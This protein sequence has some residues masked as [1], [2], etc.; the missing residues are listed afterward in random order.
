MSYRLFYHTD[1]RHNLITQN[2]L[3]Y[4]KYGL[5][6]GSIVSFEYNYK[7]YFGR[8]NR[9]T[10]RASI[11]VEDDE[12]GRLHSDGKRYLTFYVPLH[13]LEKVDSLEKVVELKD[14]KNIIND[15]HTEENNNKKP[16]LPYLENQLM[17][18]MKYTIILKECRSMQKQIILFL[19]KLNYFKEG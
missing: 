4:E 2:E 18:W 15:A 19:L 17:F 3:G 9:I 6:S 11:L 7:K 16:N 10:K 13:C 8:I 5:K 14:L 12:E 1:N